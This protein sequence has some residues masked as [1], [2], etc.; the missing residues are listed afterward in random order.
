MMVNIQEYVSLMNWQKAFNFNQ[1]FVKSVAFV[2]SSD[3]IMAIIARVN[4]RQCYTVKCIYLM[5][6]LVLY[7]K[8]STLIEACL[9]SN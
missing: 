5:S 8:N 2:V 4:C 3:S 7:L 1:S 9:Y 6:L